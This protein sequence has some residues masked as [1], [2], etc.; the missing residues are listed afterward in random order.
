MK[1]IIAL[2]VFVISCII[3]NEIY[4]QDYQKRITEDSTELVKIQAS[5]DGL[6]AQLIQ[7]KKNLNQ[8][9]KDEVE[10]KMKMNLLK[11]EME[12]YKDVKRAKI[13]E[14]TKIEKKLIKDRNALN[15][16]KKKK[17]DVKP[18]VV[19]TDEK[20]IQ[21]IV[22]YLNSE[23]LDN[24]VRFKTKIDIDGNGSVKLKADDCIF[25]FDLCSIQKINDPTKFN[26][27]A[28]YDFD[29]NCNAASECCLLRDGKVIS[30]IKEKERVVF[31]SEKTAKIFVDNLNDI[32]KMICK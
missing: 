23:V 3:T 29:I 21:E 20:I 28:F 31:L 25:Q 11:L 4:A 10:L 17:Q 18:L 9:K 12:S 26:D 15:D 5:L 13:S 8:L 16:S 7:N 24:S 2:S 32:Q 1:C 27:T 6:D 19:K 30:Q 14:R 22:E